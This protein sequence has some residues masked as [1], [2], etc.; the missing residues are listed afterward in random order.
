MA[1]LAQQILEFSQLRLHPASDRR[2]PQHE[3]AAASPDGAVMRRRL[4]VL[5]PGAALLTY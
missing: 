2:P 1:T 3:T 4:Y 5:S